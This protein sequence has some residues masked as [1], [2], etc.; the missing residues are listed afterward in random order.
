MIHLQTDGT[1]RKVLL[2]LENSKI[3]CYDL[4][5]WMNS[6]QKAFESDLRSV[7]R[8]KKYGGHVVLQSLLK[9]K[10]SLLLFQPK[11]E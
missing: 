10:G 11:Y 6:N 2:A 5:L 3:N 9:K 7:G 4:L 8:S 1:G